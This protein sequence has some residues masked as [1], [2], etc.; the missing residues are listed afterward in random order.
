M[1]KVSNQKVKMKLLSLAAKSTFPL[2]PFY[3]INNQNFLCFHSVM[4]NGFQPISVRVSQILLPYKP[5]SVSFPEYCAKPHSSSNHCTPTATKTLQT[6]PQDWA[7]LTLYGL[8][9]KRKMTTTMDF[10]S[11]SSALESC[12]YK[13]VPWITR[14]HYTDKLKLLGVISK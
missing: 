14:L 1:K 3:K 5:I 2:F 8:L 11:A 4:G 6:N 12:P 7:E 13:F 9:Q 10:P